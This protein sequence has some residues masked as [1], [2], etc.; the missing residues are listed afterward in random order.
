M[1]R[2]VFCRGSRS[3]ASGDGGS[4]RRRMS[5]RHLSGACGA[6]LCGPEQE[7]RCRALLESPASPCLGGWRLLR[8]RL[9]ILREFA[10]EAFHQHVVHGVGP[11]S[12]VDDV[13]PDLLLRFVGD[14]GEV[15]AVC[16]V[17]L[18]AFDPQFL[19]A[20]ILAQH[21]V[22]HRFHLLFG[23]Q[24]DRRGGEQVVVVVDEDANLRT[25]LVE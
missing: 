13:L 22:Q 19:G 9:R 3:E 4:A 21:V 10:P 6:G 15:Y 5:S 25:S 16:D 24:I 2:T 7:A 8:V 12:Q 18:A 1:P 23:Q 17:D 14:V 20:E 11:Q